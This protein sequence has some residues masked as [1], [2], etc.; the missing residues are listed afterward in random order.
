MNE[1]LQTD[2]DADPISDQTTAVGSALDIGTSMIIGDRA[3]QQDRLA[4]GVGDSDDTVLAVLADGMGGHD[5]GAVAS[6][7]VVNTFSLEA[8]EAIDDLG[9]VDTAQSRLH[10][11]LLLSNRR[12]HAFA[13]LNSLG[14]GCGT[15]VVSYFLKGNTICWLSVGDSSLWL[16]TAD[17]QRRLNR[18]HSVAANLDLMVAAGAMDKEDAENHPHRNAI[19]SAVT[20]NDIPQIDQGRLDLDAPGY[21]VLASDG[22]E[23]LSLDEIADHIRENPERSAQ[24]L[25]DG[26]IRLVEDKMQPEQDNTSVVVVALPRFAHEGA[27]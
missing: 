25:S 1:L 20:G 3:E 15:T 8:I 26:L 5:D 21:L 13:K 2:A 17:G 16:I 27:A 24:E 14:S 4:F 23:T 18:H 10:E 19:T 6:E 12:L 22:L 7:L 9:D 11:A